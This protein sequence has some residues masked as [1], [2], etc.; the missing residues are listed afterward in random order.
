MT[1]LR[2]RL[3]KIDDAALRSR[4]IDDVGTMQELIQEGLNYARRAQITEP[5]ASFALDEL[6]DVIV[7]DAAASTSKPVTFIQR[8][9]CD[10]EARPR[11]L[12]RC[13][14]NLLD[15]ALK[16]GNSAEVS[17]AFQDGVVQVR[18]RDHGPGIWRTNLLQSSIRLFV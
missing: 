14:S 13:L 1:R 5:F 10:V 6:L 18:I 2:L 16:Y 3:E 11:A 8:C 7:D 12:Q 15:N 9:E 17:A 4:L